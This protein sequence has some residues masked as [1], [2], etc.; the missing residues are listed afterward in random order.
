MQQ[1]P[2]AE[3]SEEESDELRRWFRQPVHEIETPISLQKSAVGST[4][5][6]QW[7]SLHLD[8]LL[9]H[10]Q[11]CSPANQYYTATCV[12]CHQETNAQPPVQVHAISTSPHNPSERVRVSALNPVSASGSLKIGSECV[13]KLTKLP[14]PDQSQQLVTLSRLRDLVLP[15]V[16]TLH[17]VGTC[18]KNTVGW[19][20]IEPCNPVSLMEQIKDFTNWN[21]GARLT[22]GDAAAILHAV[23]IGVQQLHQHNLYPWDLGPHNVLV[24][25][26]GSL[27][28]SD[29]SLVNAAA[30]A[31]SKPSARAEC[32]APEMRCN[33]DQICDGHSFGEASSVWS[34]GCM[35][36]QLLHCRTGHAPRGSPF[37]TQTGPPSPELG[38]KR[39]A[40]PCPKCRSPNQDS[41]GG[42]MSAGCTGLA[43]DTTHV[44]SC[45][46][47]W[48]RCGWL[49]PGDGLRKLCLLYTSPSPR[50]S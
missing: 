24:A 13:V 15:G 20:A 4:L 34:L 6:G 43:V 17:E 22:E 16:A 26:D 30:G 8:N 48:D 44:Q 36:W 32:Q 3:A 7:Y 12:A 18:N 10:S 40:D 11:H 33:H 27:R 9:T 2:G 42:A 50:D 38:P 5:H 23:G 1:S 35:L 47:L 14:H 49:E 46:Y 39:C 28:I 25:R 29:F 21:P 41:C 45:G 37:E 31:A 19:I